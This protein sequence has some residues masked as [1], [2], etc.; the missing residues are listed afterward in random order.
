MK[1]FGALAALSILA[2]FGECVVFAQTP[3]RPIV[4]YQK[5]AASLVGDPIRGKAVFENRQKAGCISCHSLDG[6]R[7]GVGPDLAS[8]R[9]K[10]D[11]LR[12]VESVLEPC[13]ITWDG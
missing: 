2:G 11:P 8:I 13:Y 6:S 7:T 12:L 10:Y 1:A 9:F 5:L 4:A 3:E